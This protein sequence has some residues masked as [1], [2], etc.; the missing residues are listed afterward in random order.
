MVSVEE[1]KAFLRQTSDDYDDLIGAMIESAVGTLDPA[2]NGWL[3][4]ALRPQTWELRQNQF[5]HYNLNLASEYHFGAWDWHYTN[6]Y[7]QHHHRNYLNSIELP[8]PPLISVTSIKYDD[9]NGDEQ[10]LVEDTDYRVV[11]SNTRQKAFVTPIYG[12]NW[13]TSVRNDDESVRIRF[14]A[15]YDQE[16]T[17]GDKLPGPIKQAVLLMVRTI[18]DLSARNLFVSAESVE[19]VGSRSFIV[20]ETGANLLRNASENL[21]QNLRVY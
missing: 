2:S 17:G 4:R 20:T 10:T 9:G 16:A 19:G 13:P 21:L 8:Y 3:G 7:H 5:G 12:G 11:G 6:G 15:G 18:Y 1:A 14:Q